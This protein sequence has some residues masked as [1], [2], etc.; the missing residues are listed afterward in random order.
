MNTNAS[1]QQKNQEALRVS[2]ASAP[3]QH[4]VARKEKS[5]RVRGSHVLLL[6]AL[7]AIGP[8]STDMYLPSLPTISHALGATVSLTQMTLTASLVGGA[9]GRMIIVPISAAG[10]RR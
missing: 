9:L 5:M 7:S 2:G 6:G 8:L 3:E 10:R 1:E 4:V